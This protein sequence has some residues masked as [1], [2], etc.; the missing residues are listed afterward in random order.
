MVP[1]GTMKQKSFI[2]VGEE[3]SMKLFR[4]TSAHQE[5]S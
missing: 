3:K 5:R 4:N 1:K 2:A